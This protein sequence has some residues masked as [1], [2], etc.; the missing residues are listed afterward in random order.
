MKWLVNILFWLQAFASSLIIAAIIGWAIGRETVFWILLAAG[1]VSGTLLAEYIRRKIG[2]SVFFAR[3]YSN[4]PQP[5]ADSK[6]STD[7]ST[8]K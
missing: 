7:A 8:D 3:L 4:P 2:L 6:K 5:D 1:L